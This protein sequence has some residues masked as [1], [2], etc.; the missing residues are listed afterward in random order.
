VGER[1]VLTDLDALDPKRRIRAISEDNLDIVASALDACHCWRI[2]RASG[3]VTEEEERAIGWPF[4]IANIDALEEMAFAIQGFENWRILARRSRIRSRRL[5]SREEYVFF[6]ERSEAFAK[7]V[8]S[9]KERL[10]FGPALFEGGETLADSYVALEAWRAAWEERVLTTWHAENDERDTSGS[11]PL[12]S[13]EELQS[14]IHAVPRVGCDRGTC[15]CHDDPAW[16]DDDLYVEGC[17]RC[18]CRRAWVEVFPEEWPLEEKE[19]ILR[20]I[21]RLRRVRVEEEADADEFVKLV[22]H[23]VD[24]RSERRS[25]SAPI[26]S[27]RNS[28]D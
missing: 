3:D 16:L 28:H 1:E 4:E 15:D 20:E 27:V 12:F 26:G 10:P 18:G 21:V 8:A 25:Q 7:A 13:V 11:G 22:R 19:T 14:T 23:L 9:A 5:A 2:W 6:L 24:R 17:G